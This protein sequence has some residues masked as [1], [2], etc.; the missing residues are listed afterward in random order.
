MMKSPSV[1]TPA[2]GAIVAVAT[3]AIAPG[4]RRSSSSAPRAAARPCGS[5]RARS[6]PSP[7]P[8][9][10]RLGRPGASPTK[11]L[12]RIG[13][14]PRISSAIV[15]LRTP[16]PMNATMNAISASSGIARPALPIATASSS[17][18]PAMAEVDPDRDRDRAGDREG[19]DADPDLRP[20][21]LPDLVEAPDLGR[22]G[23]RPC[24]RLED[25]LDRVRERIDEVADHDRCAHTGRT[26]RQGD[27]KPLRADVEDVEA[28]RHRDRDRAAGDDAGLERDVAVDLRAEPARA[29]EERER[30]D[31]DRRDRGDPAARR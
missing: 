4:A 8:R 13:G 6:S 12:V 2:S 18:G 21:Q 26:R 15:T 23:P 19:E 11:V 25:E 5:P 17:P 20:H 22:R 29:G 28:D 7:V 24:L 3:I 16:T 30:R 10:S 1:S 27:E 31:R 14:I 9:R